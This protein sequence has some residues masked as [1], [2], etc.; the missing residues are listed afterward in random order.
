MSAPDT[1]VDTQ[2]KRHRGPIVGIVTVLT[3][4]AVLFVAFLAWSADPVGEE[5]A[6]PAA[7][8]TN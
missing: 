6:P 4:A 5:T 1:N 7:A 2:A 8:A 3:F